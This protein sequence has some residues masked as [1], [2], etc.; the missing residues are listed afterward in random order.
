MEAAISLVIGL[1]IIGGIVYL[2]FRPKGQAG[3]EGRDAYFY[4]VAFLG[5]VILFWAAADLGR[6]ILEQQWVTDIYWRGRQD[7]TLRKVSLRLATILVTLPVFAFHWFK[8][9]MKSGEE[10]DQSSRKNYAVTVLVLSSLVVLGAGT[11]LV[12]QGLN[13]LLG[14]GEGD[15]R[16]WAYL[17]PYATTGV[18]VWLTHFRVWQGVKG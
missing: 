4:I 18:L 14:V 17:V 13:S 3:D 16:I 1:A 10:M 7:E 9:S 2:V 11:G 15:Y 5:L 6:V 12:Y 8:A